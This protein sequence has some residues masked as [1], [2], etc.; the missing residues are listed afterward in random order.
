MF[1]SV[2]EEIPAVISALV[3]LWLR[4]RSLGLIAALEA[5]LALSSAAEAELWPVPGMS[6]VRVGLLEALES[7]LFWYDAAWSVGVP[8]GVSRLGL[9]VVPLELELLSGVVTPV[10]ALSDWDG[11]VL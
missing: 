1:V 9:A 3:T 2:C 5:A 4:A 8:F 11:D 7:V 10:V 6:G